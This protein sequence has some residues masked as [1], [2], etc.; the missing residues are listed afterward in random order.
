MAKGDSFLSTPEK[1]PTGE[2]K[3]HL[4]IIITNADVELNYVVVSVTTLYHRNIQDCSCILQKSDHNFIKHKSIVDFKRTKIM[5]S[6]EIANGILKGLLIPKD[7]VRDD[8]LQ[9]IIEAAK[10]SRYISTEIKTM[11]V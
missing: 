11:L 10:K 6:V 3:R 5:S 1:T 8:V 2:E 4:R 7:S 9:R